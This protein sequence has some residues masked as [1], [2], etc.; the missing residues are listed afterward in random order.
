[1]K[2]Q[3]MARQGN[4][5]LYTIKDEVIEFKGIQHEKDKDF[6]TEVDYTT[7]QAPQK[8]EAKEF[9]LEFLQDGEKKFLNW[10]QWR[11]LRA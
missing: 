5:V 11:K 3:I 10:M 7:R 4:T 1:M 6:V 9:V 8:E 2:S